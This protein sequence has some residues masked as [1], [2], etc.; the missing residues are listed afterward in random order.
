M[1]IRGRSVASN[2]L[3]DR[4]IKAG[5]LDKQWTSYKIVLESGRLIDNVTLEDELV[6]YKNRIYIS[7]CNDLK[8]P[9]T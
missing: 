1:L 3:A 5:A 4:I 7:D 6:C 2:E 9:V 8:L